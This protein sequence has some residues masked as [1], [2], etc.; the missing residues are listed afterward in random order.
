M[1]KVKKSID[2]KKALPLILLAA[3]LSLTACRNSRPPEYT[4]VRLRDGAVISFSQ[5]IKE[6]EGVDFVFV[7]EV[8]DSE[9]S[10]QVQLQIIKELHKRRLPLAVGFEMFWAKS[11]PELNKWIAGDMDEE[12]FIRLYYRNWRLPWPYYSDILLYLRKQKIPMVG[13][14]IPWQVSQKVASNGAA[15]L[16]KEELAELPPGLSCDVSPDYKAFIRKVFTEHANQGGDSFQNFCEAQVLWDKVMAWHL[17][18]HEKKNPA[19]TVV[20][21]GVVHAL[22]RGIPSQVLKLQKKSTIRIIVPEAP[23]I[24]MQAITEKLADYLILN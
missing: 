13:L 22:K 12:D 2:L 7:G 8:H 6:I 14:N 21:S 11:Q 4:I 16:T 17:V 20:L 1:A 10:H 18:E 23:G 19:T 15:S 3:V 24:N 9:K 5:M